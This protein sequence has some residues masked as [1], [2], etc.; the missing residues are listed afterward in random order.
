MVG[1]VSEEAMRCQRLAGGPEY[2]QCARDDGQ[3]G[4]HK[5]GDW[6]GNRT[7]AISSWRAR[8]IVRQFTD[9]RRQ[10]RRVR[11]PQCRAVVAGFS[12]GGTYL[13]CKG[14]RDA[15]RPER[16]WTLEPCGHVFAERIPRRLARLT[17]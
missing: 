15:G 12:C 9:L 2:E 14:I 7:P 13:A 10:R 6:S 11:C 16:E 5:R 1:R 3:K 8:R 17:T 4:R